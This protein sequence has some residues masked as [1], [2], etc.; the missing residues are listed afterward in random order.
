MD[1]ILSSGFLAF[2]RHLGFLKAV[3]EHGLSVDAVCGT[4]SG[5]LVG[6]LWAAGH[7]IEKITEELRSLAPWNFLSLNWKIWQGLFSMRKL[8]DKLEQL[9]PAKFEGLER[10]FGVGLCTSERK[11]L[12]MREGPLPLA[13]AASCAMPYIFAPVMIGGVPYCDGGTVDRIQASGWR[14]LRKEQEM[15]VHIVNRSRGAKNEQ[16]LEGLQIVRTPRSGASF[17]SLGDFHGQLEEARE[18]THLSFDG[19]A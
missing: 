12:I 5:A 14:R 9:L 13:V 16:G 4:S 15:L 2:A 18:L 8:I 6:S 7:S 10:E 3:N 17:F 1:L 11:A 19:S